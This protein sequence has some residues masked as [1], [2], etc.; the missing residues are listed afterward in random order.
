MVEN[1]FGKNGKRESDQAKNGRFLWVM[2][3]VRR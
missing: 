2:Q 3:V 1:Y